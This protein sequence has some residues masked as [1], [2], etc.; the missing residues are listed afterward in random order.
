MRQSSSSS[1]PVVCLDGGMISE[2]ARRISLPFSTK[3]WSLR[4]LLSKQGRKAIEELHREYLAA[5]ADLVETASYNV[6]AEALEALGFTAS[7]RDLMVAAVECAERAG[8]RSDQIVYAMGPSGAA[9]FAGKE[10]TDDGRGRHDAM[11]AFHRYCFGIAPGGISLPA[12]T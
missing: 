2:V 5:G 10:Y 12:K 1:P 4:P 11:V 6:S 8:A 7:T 9:A 3:G